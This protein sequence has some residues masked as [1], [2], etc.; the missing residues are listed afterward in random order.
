M[1]RA[2]STVLALDLLRKIYKRICPEVFVKRGKNWQDNPELPVAVFWNAAAWKESFLPQFLPEYR[3]FFSKNFKDIARKEH[4]LERV[5]APV[6]ITW[7]C[8]LPEEVAEIAAKRKIEIYYMED[9]FIRSAQ[10]GAEHILPW[11]LVLDRTG[12]YYDATRPSD[13]ENLLN[14]HNFAADAQYMDMARQLLQIMLILKVSKYNL[15]RKSNMDFL[16]PKRG[17]KRVLVIG[18]VAGDAS[19]TYGLASDWS[20]EKLLAKALD[21]NPGAEIWYRPHPETFFRAKKR[22]IPPE[23]AGESR[24]WLTLR[25]EVILAELLENVDHVYTMTSLAG[26]E[27]LIHGAEVSTVGMPFYAGWGLTH[28]EKTC[29]RRKRK[30]TLEELF[31]G[32]YLLYPRYLGHIYDPAC[33]CLHAMVNVVEHRF[34]DFPKMH[35]NNKSHANSS[36]DFV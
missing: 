20:D 33:G 15:E 26:M 30:L 17:K 28:D 35:G 6:F 31:C 32:V 22:K 34:K 27:A 24:F 11:S 7:G 36:I 19:L 1:H 14:F 25:Q 4:W 12:I 5:A 18:Q 16:V 10:L 13:L 8:R 23:Y 3:V 29:D 2:W 9:G 21:E